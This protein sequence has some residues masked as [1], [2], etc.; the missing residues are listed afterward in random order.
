MMRHQGFERCGVVSRDEALEELRIAKP[1][2][3]SIRPE[4][5]DLVECSA[6]RFDG[7]VS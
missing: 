4:V 2:E 3:G 5:S 7:R 6:S 1:C